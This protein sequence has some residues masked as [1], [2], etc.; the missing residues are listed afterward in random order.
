M[1]KRIGVILAQLEENM[2]KRFMQA[3]LKEAYAKDYDVCIFSMY[4]KFQQYTP[5]NMPVVLTRSAF[6]GSQ[7]YGVFV[8]SG[9]VGHDWVTLRRQLIGGLGYVSTGLP[10]WTYD[11]GGFSRPRDQ[12]TSAWFP[13]AV[14]SSSTGSTTCGW[15]QITRSFR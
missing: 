4:Q 6:A 14:V 13:A 2:Q 12:Y 7:K 11:A 3:F 10:W 1:R 9:D 15:A 5:D 8:W